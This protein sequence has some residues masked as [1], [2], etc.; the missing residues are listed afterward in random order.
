V[1][2]VFTVADVLEVL[3]VTKHN[4]PLLPF[5]DAMIVSLAA[6]ET[7]Q[8]VYTSQVL[9]DTPS[10]FFTLSERKGARLV[11]NKG[12]LGDAYSGTATKGRCMYYKTHTHIK[13]SSNTMLLSF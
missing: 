12:M 9:R 1:G 7:E 3:P 13:P 5:A 8:E 6:G 11:T 2:F 4:I 10:V